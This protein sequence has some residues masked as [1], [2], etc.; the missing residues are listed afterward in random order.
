MSAATFQQAIAFILPHEEE[1]ARGHWG[2]ER[3]VITEHV[4]GDHGGTTKYGID[5]ASHPEVAVENLTR[6][7]AI[8]IYAREWQRHGLDAL[9]PKIAIAMFD[10]WVN[11]GYPVQW[12]QSAIN[13]H[14]PAGMPRLVVDGQL[15]PVTLSEALL[16][17]QDA[18]LR[19]F[20]AERDA[21]FES[22][23]ANHP[24]DQQFLAGWKQRD[25]DLAAYLSGLA[26][27]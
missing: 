22:L 24:N 10:V 7:G 2:D 13:D 16:C 4:P 19:D 26:V 9:P 5:Q 27:A 1:F 25:K 23:A 14:R 17:D 21:R 18:V 11:G 12:L 6:E 20:L 8:A 15:G 3:F